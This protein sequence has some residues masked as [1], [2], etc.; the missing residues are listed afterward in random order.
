M[1][2]A[3]G[4]LECVRALPEERAR[5]AHGVVDVVRI[6]WGTRPVNLNGGRSNISSY[7]ASSGRQHSFAQE[8]NSH[9]TAVQNPCACASPEP[10]VDSI[11]LQLLVLGRTS[12]LTAR[13]TGAC[14][15]TRTIATF[16]APVRARDGAVHLLTP[17]HER[18]PAQE[19]RFRGPCPSRRRRGPTPEARSGSRPAPRPRVRRLPRPTPAAR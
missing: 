13:R 15:R 14:R 8:I 9:F 7:A 5:N 18:A 17:V 4:V 16:V 2:A 12:A 3:V 19:C 1:F 6:L 11:L 10:A